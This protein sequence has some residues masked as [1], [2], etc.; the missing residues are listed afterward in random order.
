[1]YTV[2]LNAEGS[3]AIPADFFLQFFQYQQRPLCEGLPGKVPT[4]SKRPSF[5]HAHR[6]NLA[7]HLLLTAVPHFLQN[8]LLY[9]H[10]K[11]LLY[12]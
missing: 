5:T 2:C 10:I 11:A 3:P 6:H 12:G 1:M 8:A 7:A 4:N 9:P